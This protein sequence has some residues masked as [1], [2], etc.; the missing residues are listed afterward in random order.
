MPD[1]PST[2]KVQLSLL[3]MEELILQNV[4]W[5]QWVTVVGSHEVW[6]L[7][8]GCDLREPE[9]DG[10]SNE[11]QRN[12]CTLMHSIEKVFHC[13]YDCFQG[14][15]KN[16]LRYQIHCLAALLWQGGKF[17]KSLLYIYSSKLGLVWLLW[18][19]ELKY[20][21]HTMHCLSYQILGFY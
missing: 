7:H 18:Q 2:L 15:V 16:Y 1:I 14:I 19:M 10:E 17:V 6:L 12:K 9:V 3:D 13:E 5:W 4:R 8:N 20:L 21:C 11:H